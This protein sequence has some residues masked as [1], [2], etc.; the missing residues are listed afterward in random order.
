MKNLVRPFVLMSVALFVATGS[1]AA[2]PDKPLKTIP[3][4]AVI[5]KIS[6]EGVGLLDQALILGRIDIQPGDT[7]TIERVERIPARLKTLVKP[8]AFA[9]KAGSKPGR[10]VLSISNAEGC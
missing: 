3:V 4:D 1:A 6:F 2:A 8:H 9:Y 10:V 5:E 7:L